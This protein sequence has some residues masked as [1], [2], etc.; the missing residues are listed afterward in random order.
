MKRLFF[1]IAVCL[2]VSTL[3][4]AKMG[5]WSGETIAPETDASGAYEIK[6]AENLAWVAK[7]SAGTDFAGKVFRLE[8]DLDLGG[9][10]AVP[11]KWQPIGSAAYPFRGEFDGNN[12]VISNL[13]ING[14]FPTCAGL[15]S[16]TGA[17][18]TIHNLGLAQGKIVADKTDN[19]GVIVGINRGQI[20]HC[21]SMVQIALAGNN[22]GGLVG[23]NEGEIN[24]SYNTGIITE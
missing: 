16:E 23:V 11:E 6:T 13:Y 2:Q 14:S 21:F 5:P 9:A 15:F 10:E 12:H 18:A 7:Q 8:A 4:A 1:S 19:V 3:W 24:Y 22:I 20:H 17:E